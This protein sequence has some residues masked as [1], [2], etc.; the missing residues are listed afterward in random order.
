MGGLITGGRGLNILDFGFRSGWAVFVCIGEEIDAY[1]RIS[2]PR[3]PV[4]TPVYGQE[5]RSRLQPR[6][7]V[8]MFAFEEG[9]RAVERE[10]DTTKYWVVKLLSC[11]VVRDERRSR[12]AQ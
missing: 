2:C 9:C 5:C 7:T 8:E 3:H 4:R 10:K 11:V 6:K 12:F 1:C